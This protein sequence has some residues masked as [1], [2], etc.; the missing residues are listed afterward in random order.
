MF[1]GLDPLGWG[2]D[3]MDGYGVDPEHE[4]DKEDAEFVD[5]NFPL[6]SAVAILP[7]FAQ[8]T[9]FVDKIMF[10]FAF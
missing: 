5:V 1:L 9:Y 2:F 10:L 3:E 7:Y 6:I 8:I 4:L